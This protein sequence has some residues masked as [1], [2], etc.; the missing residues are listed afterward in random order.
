MSTDAKKRT[1]TRQ[2]P[3]QVEDFILGW[4]RDSSVSAGALFRA[5]EKEF[6]EMTAAERPSKRTVQDMVREFRSRPGG[7]PIPKDGAWKIWDAEP[8][9]AAAVLGVLAD[10]MRMSHGET[11]EI[12]QEDAK[13]I[14]R[15]SRAGVGDLPPSVLHGLA[16]QYQLREDTRALDALIAFTPWRSKDAHERYRRAVEP[17]GSIPISLMASTREPWP[18]ALGEY[19]Q[20]LMRLGFSKRTSAQAENYGDA[21]ELEGGIPWTSLAAETVKR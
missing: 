8:E 15:L 19:K 12:S 14:I 5:M 21:L 4:A 10:L 17:I 2:H 7:G 6:K 9:D 3:P 11:T 16:I 13:W 1:V 18:G 20:L